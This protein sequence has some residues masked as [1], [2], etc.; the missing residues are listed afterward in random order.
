M[1]EGVALKLRQIGNLFD[2]IETIDAA[3]DEEWKTMEEQKAEYL[4]LIG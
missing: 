4:V 3:A 2:A 1:R